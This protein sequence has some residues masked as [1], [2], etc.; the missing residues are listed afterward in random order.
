MRAVNFDR[1]RRGRIHEDHSRRSIKK[2]RD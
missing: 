2:N 1:R